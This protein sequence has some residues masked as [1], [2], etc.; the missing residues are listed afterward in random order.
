[1]N[2][3]TSLTL[4]RIFMVPFLVVVLLAPPSRLADTPF[5]GTASPA[6]REIL[7]VAIF[8][9][10]I[11]TDFLD[12]FLARRRDQVTT[13]GTLLDPIADKLLTSAAFISLVEMGLAPAW[14]VVIIVG[15]EF[16]VSGLRS[17]MATQGVALPASSLGKLKTTVQAVAIVLL[18]L[19]RSLDRW[20]RW[21]YLGVWAL[22]ISM[23]IALISAVDYLVKFVRTVELGAVRPDAKGRAG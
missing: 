4:A 8:L 18:I 19:T 7:G 6:L 14:M 11:L 20:G 21:G 12:G 17:V 16:V 2:L 5:F 13:L 22:W 23:I 1:M 15:R 3:P 9:V 10:A